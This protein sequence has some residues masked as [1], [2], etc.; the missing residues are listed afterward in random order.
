MRPDHSDPSPA[1]C[2]RL[3]G[4]VQR[5]GSKMGIPTGV[6]F[7]FGSLFVAVGT[8][9]TLMGTKVVS[10]NPASVRAPYWVLTVAG[11]SFALGG[12]AVWGMAGKQFAADRQR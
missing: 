8:Y 11:V 2:R 1:G 9:I 5:R 4:P 10:V 3:S 12:M 6:G 7:L